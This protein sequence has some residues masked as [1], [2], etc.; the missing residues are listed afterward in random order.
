[1]KDFLRFLNWGFSLSTP[2]I[3]LHRRFF[4]A[5]SSFF[6]ATGAFTERSVFAV[7]EG[8]RLGSGVKDGRAETLFMMPSLR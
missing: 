3:A 5:T 4:D 2:W 6:A 1:L 8:V 7:D